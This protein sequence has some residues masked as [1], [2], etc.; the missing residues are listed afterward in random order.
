MGENDLWARRRPKRL[1]VTL[2]HFTGV[3]IHDYKSCWTILGPL[4]VAIGAPKGLV[5]AQ[6]SPIL[7]G[8]SPEY[9]KALLKCHKTAWSTLTGWGPLTL[10]LLPHFCAFWVIFNALLCPS[11]PGAYTKVLEAVLPK[12]K[13]YCPSLPLNIFPVRKKHPVHCMDTMSMLKTTCFNRPAD[14]ATFTDFHCING[15]FHAKKTDIERTVSKLI[16]LVPKH[17]QTAFQDLQRPN[18][19]Y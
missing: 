14:C 18:M 7:G 8:K 13:L 17:T 3:I 16:F 1:Q 15:R 19:T 11:G 12:K 2:K 10:H 4:W 5:W 9:P 6:N